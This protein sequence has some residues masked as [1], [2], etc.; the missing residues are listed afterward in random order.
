M[1]EVADKHNM[2]TVR[3]FTGHG[4]GSVFHAS[5]RVHGF[6][7]R[8]WWDVLGWLQW[9]V[10]GGKQQQASSV[11][12]AIWQRLPSSILTHTRMYNCGE[13]KHDVPCML[14]RA[15]AWHVTHVYFDLVHC[16]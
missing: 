16:L 8:G 14:C 9:L 12:Q 3:L 1:Q 7:P 2:P 4:I 13:D 15:G 10:A 11:V 6:T 5:P